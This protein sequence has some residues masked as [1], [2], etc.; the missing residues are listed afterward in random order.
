MGGALSAP[1]VEP[2]GSLFKEYPYRYI[3]YLFL[4]TT[5]CYQFRLEKLLYANNIIN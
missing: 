2:D 1:S 5:L 4:S 3:L